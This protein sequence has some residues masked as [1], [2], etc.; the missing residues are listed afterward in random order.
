MS[1]AFTT[2]HAPQARPLLVRGI[3]GIVFGVLALALPGLALTSLLLLFAA[4][5]LVD[6]V[7]AIVAAARAARHREPWG[8]LAVEGAVT[9]AAGAATVL[10]P[11]LTAVALVALLGAWACVSGVLLAIAAYSARAEAGRG[12]LALAGVVSILWGVLLLGWPG[13]GAIAI[14]VWLGAYALVFGVLLVTTGMRLRRS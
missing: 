4:Y 8:W 14:V 6:G 1:E 11:G 9:L 5:L 7:F 10:M 12:W 2:T 3:A 13:A